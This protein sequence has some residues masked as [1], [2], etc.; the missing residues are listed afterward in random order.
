MHLSSPFTSHHLYASARRSARLLDHVP[1]DTLLL[2]LSQEG[3]QK[4]DRMEWRRYYLL[5]VK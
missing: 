3:C 2:V 4:V 5:S 1:L